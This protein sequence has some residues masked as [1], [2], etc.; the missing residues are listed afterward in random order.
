MRS[1]SRAGHPP[2]ARLRREG[3]IRRVVRE[4]HI[5]PGRQVLVRLCPNEQG[6]ARLGMTAPRAFGRAVRRNRFRRLVREAFRA[7]AAELGAVDVFVSPRR[8][9]AVPTVEAIRAD[10]LAAPG[11]AHPPGPRKGSA[12]GRRGKGPARGRRGKDTPS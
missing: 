11:K 6:R 3:E 9:L 12:R 7:I 4:G 5:Y 2:A 1:M 8:G 10:I